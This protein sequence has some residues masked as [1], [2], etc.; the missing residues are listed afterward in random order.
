MKILVSEVCSSGI[1][2]KGQVHKCK[3]LGT[4]R[5]RSQTIQSEYLFKWIM[6]CRGINKLLTTFGHA[7]E[8]TKHTTSPENWGGGVSCPAG[9]GRARNY[10][11]LA[12]ITNSGFLRPQARFFFPFKWI[13]QLQTYS[14]PKVFKIFSLNRGHLSESF[15]LLPRPS[16]PIFL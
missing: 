11:T 14:A 9:G 5:C 2:E 15:L 3:A 10:S 13:S 4:Q 12:L 1:R 8:Q 7:T 16:G 6:S